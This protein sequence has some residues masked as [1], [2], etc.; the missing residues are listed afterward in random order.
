MASSIDTDS[1][2]GLEDQEFDYI[3]VGGGTSGLVVASR[4][5]EDPKKAI[6][7]LEAGT[8]RLEDPR[9]LILGL[10]L[11]VHGN[12]EFD[13]GFWSIPQVNLLFRY[14]YRLTGRYRSN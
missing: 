3:I 9:L 6:L 7:V 13:W 4:L 2:V 12:P 8:N 10:G 1:T 11:S 14:H 5:S